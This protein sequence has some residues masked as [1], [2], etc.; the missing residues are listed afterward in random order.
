MGALTGPAGH[1]QTR[2]LSINRAPMQSSGYALTAYRAHSRLGHASYARRPNS[3][4]IRSQLRRGTSA[5]P[6]C[7]IRSG[8]AQ[9]SPT[10][11]PRHDGGGN[12]H[13]C[14]AKGEARTRNQEP[15]HSGL[16]ESD[17]AVPERSSWAMDFDA[18][19]MAFRKPASSSTDNAH[20]LDHAWFFPEADA[21]VSRALRGSSVAASTDPM[22]LCGR[23][24]LV[25]AVSSGQAKLPR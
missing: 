5:G 7:V 11:Y 13:G 6:P 15:S 10:T 20:G 3:T 25:G 18:L 19:R 14:Y 2:S 21:T 16:A 9:V 24:S 22:V 8:K 4:R 12:A 1:C 23:S 17:R